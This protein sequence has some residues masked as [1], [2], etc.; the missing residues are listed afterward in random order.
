MWVV[1]G[2]YGLSGVVV[3]G[4][5]IVL[6]LALVVGQVEVMKHLLSATLAPRS[7][8]YCL[9]RFMP[10]TVVVACFSLQA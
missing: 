9:E 2:W 4:H 6:S 3:L 1:L 7:V 8:K 10:V 5:T